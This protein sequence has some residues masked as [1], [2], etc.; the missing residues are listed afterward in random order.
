VLIETSK[1]EDVDVLQEKLWSAKPGLQDK[2]LAELLDNW[3]EKLRQ[4]HKSL[5]TCRALL[6]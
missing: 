4:C 1:V 3:P 6:A 2:T 5:F